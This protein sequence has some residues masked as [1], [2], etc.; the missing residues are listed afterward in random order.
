MSRSEMTKK[1]HATVQQLKSPKKEQTTNSMHD[2]GCNQA[3]E[4]TVKNN[5]I[6]LDGYGSV[7]EY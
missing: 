5:V 1:H 2:A 6:E 4:K 7:V 3:K